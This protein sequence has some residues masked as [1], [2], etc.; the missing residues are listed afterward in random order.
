MTPKPH[1]KQIDQEG[2][3]TLRELLQEKMKLAIQYTL[4]QALEEEIDE[5]AILSRILAADITKSAGNSSITQ[6]AHRNGL[7]APVPTSDSG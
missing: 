2:Q 1:H 5:Q 3:A 4:I 6:F 7:W